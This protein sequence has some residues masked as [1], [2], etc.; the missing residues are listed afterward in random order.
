[1]NFYANCL[2]L[3]VAGA[4]ALLL[5]QFLLFFALLGAPSEQ[6]RYLDEWWQ[7]KEAYAHA[8][9]GK[10]ILLISG[11]NTLFGVKAELMEESLG[12]PV[13]NLG[14][15]AGLK[16]YNLRRGAKCLE[17]GDTVIIPLEYPYY[18][19]PKHGYDTEYLAYV[20]AY[21][22]DYFN[23]GSLVDK[24]AF[25][26]QWHPGDI[27]REAV[28]IIFPPT[29]RENGYSSKYLN[30]NGDMLNNKAANGKS[31]AYLQ[32]RM[33]DTVFDAYP[34]PSEEA[35]AQ[36]SWFVDFC[37]ERQVTLYAAWPSYLYRD[38]DFHGKDL[39]GIRN[40]EAFYREKG[41]EILGNYTD[42][43]YD[44]DMFYDTL[45]HLNDIGQAKHTEYLIELLKAHGV[46][47]AEDSKIP[48]R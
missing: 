8:Q 10:K 11:S 6:E 35:K 14:T 9:T 5:L 4:I 34:V 39:E 46:A 13:V 42:T 17:P 40:I 37:R 16:F 19:W 41:V 33:K 38:K 3:F 29:P 7:K 24:L 2:R 20:T 31:G 15:H 27:C 47:G 48:A 30:K 43:L 25:I 28:K 32:N 22:P 36:L 23:A 44:A 45:Y 1:M 12:M 26:Y 18:D 21:D